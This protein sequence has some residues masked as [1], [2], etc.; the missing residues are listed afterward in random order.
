MISFNWAPDFKSHT[1][2]KHHRSDQMVDRDVIE[3]GLISVTPLR[4]TFQSTSTLKGELELPCPSETQFE[5]VCAITID[6]QE[7]IYLPLKSAFQKWLPSLKIV[8]E[9]PKM[10]P[11]SFTMVIMKIWIWRDLAK[12]RNILPTLISTEKHS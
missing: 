6:P 11:L 4:A 9:L 12:I 2:S 10:I 8:S 3:D 1:D 5:G 7:Y